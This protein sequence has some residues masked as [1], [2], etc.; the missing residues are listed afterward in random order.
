VCKLARGRPG[1]ARVRTGAL[2]GSLLGIAL[3]LAS[4]R[5]AWLIG[6]LAIVVG[7]VA[8]DIAAHGAA[9]GAPVVA[10]RPDDSYAGS[11][12]TP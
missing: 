2:L 10:R 5:Q 12:A 8:L 3:V 9:L 1:S 4:T 6:E 11:G 7:I